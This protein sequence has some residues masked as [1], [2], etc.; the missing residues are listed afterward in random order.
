MPCCSWLGLISTHKSSSCSFGSW[1]TSPVAR[2]TVRKKSVVLCFCSF[3]PSLHRRNRGCFRIFYPNRC[4][5][6][7]L[8]ATLGSG[9]GLYLWE[10][11]SWRRVATVGLWRK[12]GPG[13]TTNGQPGNLVTILYITTTSRIFLLSCSTGPPGH[14]I[15]IQSFNRTCRPLF[16]QLLCKWVTRFFHVFTKSWQT[17]H[18]PGRTPMNVFDATSM[19]QMASITGQ[20]HVFLRNACVM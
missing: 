1:R 4:A 16:L 13:R 18:L 14:Q 20:S 12:E 11:S 2:Q 17:R 10:M 7:R 5:S 3:S 19:S 15:I 6:G 9:E 8:W